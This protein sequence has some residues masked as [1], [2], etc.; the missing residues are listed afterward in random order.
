MIS[1]RECLQILGHASFAIVA[2]PT[3]R[4]HTR[5]LQQM[6]IPLQ[7]TR[8]DM[9]TKVDLSPAALQDLEFW[10]NL[11]CWEAFKP[12]R[13]PPPTVR[14]FTDASGEEWGAWWNDQCLS[15]P[16]E[17][18]VKSWRINEKE[19]LAIYLSFRYFAG[20]FEGKINLNLKLKFKIKYFINLHPYFFRKTGGSLLRQH[21][22][23]GLHIALEGD[24]Q[25]T[26]R[27]VP[28]KK[29]ITADFLSRLGQNHTEW[30]LDPLVAGNLILKVNFTQ[31][32]LK[33]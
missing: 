27:H 21:H 9:E 1:L 23:P 29:N 16:W 19:L 28:G 26:T 6:V 4:L 33:N 25:V 30:K 20:F 7:I 11:T 22:C 12:I 14:L 5:G 24:I 10:R 13:L 31:K 3:A 18:E 2:V 32:I 15:H 8:A 17:E